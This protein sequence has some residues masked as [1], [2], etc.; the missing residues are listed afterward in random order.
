MLGLPPAVGRPS[1]D[2][3]EAGLL[4]SLGSNPPSDRAP[5]RGR[6]VLR[7]REQRMDGRQIGQARMT[8]WP[9]PPALWRRQWHRGL[10]KPDHRLRLER[11]G[12]AQRSLA[13]SRPKG[14]II[15]VGRVG[16]DEAD[17]QRPRPRLVD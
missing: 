3:G 10:L 2:Q 14:K 6:Q 5:S 17:W 13:Q 12:I 1:L 4:R 7:Y 8:P 15:T 9:S 16:Q 11:D